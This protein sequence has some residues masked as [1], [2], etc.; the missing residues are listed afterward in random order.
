MAITKKEVF[1]WAGFTSSDC[2]NVNSSNY[3]NLIKFY[4]LSQ[5]GASFSGTDTA[6]NMIKCGAGYIVFSSNVPYSADELVESDL[7]AGELL[8]LAENVFTQ[9]D[10]TGE[11]VI[12]T[13]FHLTTYFINNKPT[14]RTLDGSWYIWFDGTV[15]VLSNTKYTKDDIWFEG[16][17]TNPNVDNFVHEDVLFY[18]E[19]GLPL[20]IEDFESTLITEA[21]D[22]NFVQ[23]ESLFIEDGII[24]HG[25]DGEDILFIETDENPPVGPTNVLIG[26]GG[27]VGFHME[28]GVDY[29]ELE[30]A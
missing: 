25:E 21:D 17:A 30:S 4:A 3:P 16:D 6:E 12:D 24:L 7:V 1:S 2:V 15:W 18:T 5:D 23:G 9:F 29:L 27:L 8:S 19:A 13:K 26:E 22:P 20:F 10:Y 14:Y 28:D 11:P